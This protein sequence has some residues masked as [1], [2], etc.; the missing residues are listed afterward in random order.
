MRCRPQYQRNVG[1]Q[2]QQFLQVNATATEYIGLQSPWH[3]QHVYCARYDVGRGSEIVMRTMNECPIKIAYWKTLEDNPCSNE[4]N[5][6]HMSGF[7][8]VLMV[9]N[10]PGED[11]QYNKKTFK[12]LLKLTKQALFEDGFHVAVLPKGQLNPHM[13]N[14]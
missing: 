9:A 7:T 14:G 3:A 6:Y 10:A 12:L 1:G 5:V 8:P 2:Q 11:N 13:E 4:A